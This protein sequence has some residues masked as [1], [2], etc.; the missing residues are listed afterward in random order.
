MTARDGAE[1]VSAADVHRLP[2]RARL[3]RLVVA[4]AVLALTI[5]GTVVADDYAFPFGPPRM[6]ATRAD[7][8]APVSSTRVVGIDHEG[9]EVR[10]SG[11]E[12]G[13]RRAEFEGQVPRLVRHPELL[14]LLAET[15]RVNHPEA[16]PL[17][18]VAIIVRRYELDDGVRTGSY[19][20][21]VL[22]TYEVPTDQQGTA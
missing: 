11:G 9:A 14:G 1:L 4:A 13:L 10:L 15:Y 16:G 6:Y 19:T 3:V 18:A 22:I 5:A 12:V 20:D 7:P 21:D 8:D 2:P 17:V